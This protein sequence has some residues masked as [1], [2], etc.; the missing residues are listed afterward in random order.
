MTSHSPAI[1]DRAHC[2][3]AGPGA[4]KTGSQ[5]ARQTESA[6][7]PTGGSSP[8]NGRAAQRSLGIARCPVDACDV[9]P[10]RKE[11]Q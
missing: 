5:W 10:D 1:L 7:A 4:P 3:L 11:P 8:L 6:P 2:P 9:S